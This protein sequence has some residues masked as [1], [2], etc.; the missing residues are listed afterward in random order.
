ML[1]I[2]YHSACLLAL[3]PRTSSQTRPLPASLFYTAL[4]FQLSGSCKHLISEVRIKSL[5]YSVPLTLPSP[6]ASSQTS[7]SLL[8]LLSHRLSNARSCNLELQLNY[9]S[10]LLTI[11]RAVREYYSHKSPPSAPIDVGIISLD[12]LVL[13]V[14]D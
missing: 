4:A 10:S 5:I 13:L 11:T 2:D 3:S 9:Q 1:P 12:T 14:P 7:S 6:F 8:L